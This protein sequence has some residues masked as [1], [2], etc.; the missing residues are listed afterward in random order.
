MLS[1][2]NSIHVLDAFSGQPITFTVQPMVIFFG[3]TR[4]RATLDTF[5]LTAQICHQRPQQA[6]GI[7]AIRLGSSRAPILLHACRIDHQAVHAL[8]FEQTVEPESV[9]ARLV[10]RDDFDGPADL[11]SNAHAPPVF[12]D[13]LICRRSREPLS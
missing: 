7:D 3:D 8:T 13:R 9:V 6:F 5:R 11:S 10:A 2:L 12:G 4:S 1:A